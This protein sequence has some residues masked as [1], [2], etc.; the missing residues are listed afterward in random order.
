MRNRIGGGAYDNA[1][2]R[3]GI[4]IP[5]LNVG[6]DFVGFIRIIEINY[7]PSPPYIVSK[8]ISSPDR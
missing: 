4:L 1:N 2:S 6:K 7:F 3:I 5:I 8:V